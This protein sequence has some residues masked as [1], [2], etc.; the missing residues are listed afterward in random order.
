MSVGRDFKL[1]PFQQAAAQSLLDGA[2]RWIAHAADA[3]V[4]KYGTQP[5]PFLGQLRAVTGAGKT[6]ILATVLSGIGDAVVVWTT[7]SSAVVEQTFINLRGKYAPLLGSN[8]VKVIREIPSQAEW[9]ELITSTR[10]LT[11][12]VLTTA[13]WNEAESAAAGGSAEARLNLHRPHPDWAGDKSPWEQ[14]RRDLK[15]P[16]WIVSDESHNQSPVQ[17]DQL[18]ALRPKGFF[19]ASATPIAIPLFEA[20]EKALAD[21]EEWAQ[22]FKAGVVPVRTRDVVEAEL[23]KTT[24]EV[25][26]FNSGMEE[27]LDGALEALAKAQDA[28][29][30]E[31]APVDPRAIYVVEKSNPP[32]GST[33]ESRPLAIWRHLRERGVAADEI[34]VYTDT[35]ELPE[36]AERISNLGRLQPRHRHIIFNQALQEGW[37]D[38][39]AYV[40]YFD[41]V[42]RSFVR[43]RQIVGRVL[44]QPQAQRFRSEALNTAT[45]ILNMPADSYDRVLTE[46]RMELRLYAPEE[47]P[48]QPPIRVKTRRDPLPAVPIRSEWKGKLTL[49]SWTHSAPNMDQMVQRLRSRATGLWGDEFLEAPGVGRRSVVALDADTRERTEYIEVLRSARTRNG[50]YLR[51]RLA[52]RNRACVN[53]LHPDRFTGP[54]YE[55]LSCHGSVAQTELQELAAQIA[56]Y[57]E[58]RVDYQENPDPDRATWEV[59]DYLPRGRDTYDFKRAAHAEYSRAD[60]NADE[61]VFARGLDSYDRGVWVRNPAAASVGYSIPLPFKVGDSSNF[62]PDFLWWI[63]NVCWAIDTT[64]RHLLNDK[65]RGKLLDLRS[66]K[67]AFVVRGEVKEG[68]AVED[69]AGWTV[70][71]AR[72]VLGPSF[73][74]FDDLKSA[75]DVLASTGS[76]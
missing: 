8:Q 30:E 31:S 76:S 61:L 70:V 1:F 48:E 26:D 62:Y 10:G 29:V 44:R 42:T 68:G 59:G 58:E 25:L 16:L 38:P 37:D 17:L 74:H 12:W 72:R 75:L 67:V 7:K 65:I 4:P 11:V 49:P 64:G 66:P 36:D 53:A 2:L 18:A 22:L 32:R 52:Q 20:W 71:V 28:A 27:S 69:E 45:L 19:M 40:C 21:D 6:P 35:R 33:E 43:I 73:Q 23:L 41:G 51:R 47:L 39:E 5:I 50:V 15:R 56:D 13:S 55:Q 63:D 24:I 60:F 46:L 14:L 3:G 57:F 9:R 34:A 54:A